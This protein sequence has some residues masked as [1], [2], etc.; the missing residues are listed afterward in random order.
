MEPP[1]FGQTLHQHFSL[2]VLLRV[3]A[4]CD[5]GSGRFSRASSRL[6]SG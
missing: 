3:D 4:L 6:I 5:L 2:A 1:V